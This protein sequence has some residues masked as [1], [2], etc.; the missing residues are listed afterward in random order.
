MHDRTRGSWA[1]PL[2]AETVQM[3]KHIFTSHKYTIFL[4]KKRYKK[5]EFRSFFNLCK[6]E[7]P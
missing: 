7:F 2:T 6:I 4:V 3:N 5:K 1:T